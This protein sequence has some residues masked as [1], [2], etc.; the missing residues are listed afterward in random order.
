M[1]LLLVIA[2]CLH[3]QS[4]SG[5]TNF[6]EVPTDLPMN[7]GLL[8]VRTESAG[9][10]TVRVVKTFPKSPA[11]RAG[12]RKGDILLAVD[13]YRMRNIEELSRYMRSRVPGSTVTLSLLRDGE[14]LQVGSDVTDI[15]SLYFLMREQGFDPA[16]D[17]PRHSRW[18]G[19]SDALEHE[20]SELMA[21]QESEDVFST[22]RQALVT[23]AGRFGADCRL[24]DVEYALTNP[25][26]GAQLAGDIAAEFEQ[27]RGLADY[28]EVLGRHL[29]AGSD[30]LRNVAAHDS[31]WS[32]DEFVV[33]G[34]PEILTG[35]LRKAS[36]SVAAA[37]KGLS[38]HERT[39][40][41]DNAPDLLATLSR[42]SDVDEG[43]TTEAA[44]RIRTLRLAKRVDMASL[45]AAA[46]EL[47]RI[48]APRTL[49]RIRKEAA[50]LG[51]DQKQSQLPSTLRGEFVYASQ[52][53]WGWVLIG[54]RGDNFY[55]ED[56]A[57][58]VDLGGDDVYF[59][60]S[61]SPVFV[62]DGGSLEQLSPV[63]VL[64]DYDGDD[65]YLGNAWGSIGSGLGGVGLL[66]DLKG[67]DLYHGS[68]LTQGAA[69]CGVGVLWD[70]K[71]NDEYLAQDEAQGAAFF[72]AGMLLDGR[73]SDL[74]SAAQMSQAFGGSRGF[75]LL[76][77]KRGDD[78][79][80]ADRK[81]P[82][83]YGTRGVYRGWSQGVGR[84]IRGFAAGGI[85]LLLDSDGDD[86]YQAGNFSQ[87]TGYFF[88]LGL[89]VDRRGN[90]LYRGSRYCQGA[91]AHQAVGV[92]LEGDGDDSY[93]GGQGA[94]QGGAWDAS[95]SILEDRAGD[96]R[97]EGQGLSQGAAAMNG[98]GL[99]FD[100]GG[101]D[102]YFS[103]SGQG[104]G[105]S[106]T[107]WG[108]R[109]AQNMGIFIDAGG[110]AGDEYGLTDRANDTEFSA[111]RV[112]IFTD[113]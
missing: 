38:Q 28:L 30:T 39:D 86:D 62:P 56:A 25:L 88:A 99:L 24:R 104:D 111:S 84:G 9:K 81:V 5:N 74:Y 112:G 34:L 65:H 57:L 29:D 73:G 45:I 8:G 47:S 26:K 31:A 66:L 64:I 107:Y 20:A 44:E 18:S 4:V 102:R 1:I 108:G 37:F 85:G 110:D 98:V 78:R 61:G 2:A 50:K 100:W 59:N 103:T 58:I 48:A 80:L 55:G 90:D 106:T 75:G 7:Y 16:A 95:V 33:S 89:L 79:Y 6:A 71:G 69:F 40:L 13:G 87:G 17:R 92:L 49:R 35:P 10:D 54:D 91:S 27:G 68:Q 53:D 52:T 63:G 109:G 67:D 36:L 60:N 113:H 96:D 97:Y 94:N 76:Y 14:E 12:L 22:L 19:N 51:R 70:Q 77:D 11:D 41:L 3:A 82:S 46:E 32:P 101:R 15:H 93:L 21:R 23:E 42:G 83:S 105:G 72:G 43:D